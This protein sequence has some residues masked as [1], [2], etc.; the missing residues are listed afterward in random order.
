M[1]IC[2]HLLLEDG[3]AQGAFQ[4]HLQLLARVAHRHLALAPVQVGVHHAALDGAGPHDGHLDHQ[5]VIAAGRSRG[6][7]LIC[8]RL[9]I[10]NTPTVSAR[11]IM[12]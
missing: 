10:W 3:H 12:S 11:Q 5:V 1:A 7:M 4:R 6:S 8:A 9:S 2:M